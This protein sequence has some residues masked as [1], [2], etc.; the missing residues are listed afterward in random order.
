MVFIVVETE[1]R[2]DHIVSI[3]DDVVVRCNRDGLRFNVTDGKAVDADYKNKEVTNMVTHVYGHYTYLCSTSAFFLSLS[4][5]L[6]LSL[7]YVYTLTYVT[8]LL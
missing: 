5:S 2:A 3:A 7:H 6:S 1:M 8:K 4:L